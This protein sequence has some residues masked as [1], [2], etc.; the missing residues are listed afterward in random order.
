[1]T[2]SDEERITVQLQ[3][4]GEVPVT[5]IPLAF[6]VNS[7]TMHGPEFCNVDLDVGQTTNFTFAR[8][9]DF[10][11]A[12]VYDLEV[13]NQMFGD[14]DRANDRQ[15]VTIRHAA[16]LPISLPYSQSFESTTS[17]IYQTSRLLGVAGATEVDFHASDPAGILRTAFSPRTGRRALNLFC[18]RNRQYPI[19]V[20][21]TMTLNM[22]SY[23][24]LE[25]VF[26]TAWFKGDLTGTMLYWRGNDRDEFIQVDRLNG[27]S[28]SYISVFRIDISTLMRV[29]PRNGPQSFSP[30]S[31][32]QVVL[33]TCLS[34]MN[35]GVY[36]DDFLLEY[37]PPVSTTGVAPTPMIPTPQPTPK[38]TPQPI[39][40]EPTPANQPPTPT[41][42][43]TT[44]QPPQSQ[45][46]TPGTNPIDSESSVSGASILVVLL[47]SILALG[48]IAAVLFAV[49]RAVKF[50][51][52]RKQDQEGGTFTQVP[53]LEL[54]MGED[55]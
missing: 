7:G 5:S 34:T 50:I 24:G 55:E 36:F 30:S 53:M 46:S 35:D 22:A 33:P 45:T 9:W 43:R 40:P 13:V 21:V 32:F 11:A 39:T 20:N 4:Q 41:P 38:R 25:N 42:Q 37:L 1:M 23:V 2:F 51:R 19:Q 49:W 14:R 3:N 52:K 6:R 48:L 12:G 17:T 27:R 8:T 28:D 18:D 16:N 54:E 26:L 29:A 10:S 47:I 31:Q 15:R 44:T